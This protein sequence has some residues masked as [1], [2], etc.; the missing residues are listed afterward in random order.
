M[1]IKRTDVRNQNVQVSKSIS[2]CSSCGKPIMRPTVKCGET[3]CC[4]LSL[5]PE[6]Q[7][8]SENVESED[9]Q[10]LHGD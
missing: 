3:G 8:K 4:I 10:H 9:S 6:C 7:S 2:R 1:F 5:C